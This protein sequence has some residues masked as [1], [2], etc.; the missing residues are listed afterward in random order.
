M[1]VLDANILIRA[2]LGIR[3]RKLIEDHR[4]TRV[5]FLAPEAAFREA[6][7]HLPGIL[8]KRGASPDD[9]ARS[10]EY[11]EGFVDAIAEERYSK[12]EIDARR[13]LR[14]R[15][16]DDWHVLARALALGC[17]IWTEDADFFGTGVATRTTSRVEILLKK[18]ASS[19]EP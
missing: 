13:R 15:D 18:Q 9:F 5:R 4:S 12:F 2:A 8:A 14:G 6:E 3:V 11:L 10:M 19:D 1:I 16:E 7:E 17:D